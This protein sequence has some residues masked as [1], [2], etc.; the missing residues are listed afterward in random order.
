MERDE[1]DIFS[2]RTVNPNGD[3]ISGNAEEQIRRP[4]RIQV[5]EQRDFT[6]WREEEHEK[7]TSKF[8][9][10]ET[11]EEWKFKRMKAKPKDIKAW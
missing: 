5:G 2:K 6:R 8:G 7:V 9:F 3:W 4:S 11:K 1:R 10:C